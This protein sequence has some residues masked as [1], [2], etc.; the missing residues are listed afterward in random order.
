MSEC[1]KVSVVMPAYNHQEYV[2]RSIDSVISQTYPNVELIVVDD[3]STDKTWE[4]ISEKL[5]DN[6]GLFKAISR[7]NGGVCSALN[8]GVALSSGEFIAVI[9]S[10]DYY[11]PTKLSE[12]IQLFLNLK[13][14]V[15]LV[16]SGAYLD[17]QNGQD[18][19]DITGSY[20]PAVGSCLND[21]LTQKVR[22]VAPSIIFRR[23]AFDTVG[24]F[25]EE[26]EAEDVDFFMRLA[27]A[28]YEF[29]YIAKPL[30]VK[31][32]VEKSAGSNF[33][34]LIKV[35]EAI[36]EK[37]RP[38]LDADQYKSIKVAMYDHLIILSSGS[39]DYQLAWE[40]AKSLF[41]ERRSVLPIVSF[42]VWSCRS[43]FLRSLPVGLRHR[44]RLIRSKLNSSFCSL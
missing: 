12:Q 11:L 32:V 28:G 9:A 35:H 8:E 1:P 6:P 30:V 33:S 25:D 23:S 10:D 27:Q 4:K 43:M 41:L 14:K 22:I 39:G 15:A 26:L 21:V 2:G 34:A 17:Y 20:K 40:T 38:S 44:L 37:H 29:A 42:M 31:T 7:K 19:E 13:D 18:F 16:H 36:L 5:N 24:G 3:G